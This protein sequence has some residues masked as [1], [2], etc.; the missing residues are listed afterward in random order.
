MYDSAGV[1][2]VSNTDVGIWRPG[3]E[4][5][6]EEELRIGAVEGDPGYLFGEIWGVTVDSQ[7]RIFVLDF[8]S[9]HI[10]VYSADGVYEQT[11]GGPGEGPGELRGAVSI[12]MGPGDTLLVRD[13]RAYRFNRYSPDGS[14][15]PGFRMAV[16]ERRLSGLKATPS[17]VMVEQFEARN[18][19]R[20]VFAPSE[21]LEEWI[22]RL[23]TDGTILDTLLAYSSSPLLGPEGRPHRGGR[24][25]IPE[26]M[27]DV[28]DDLELVCGTNDEYRIATYSN[29][30]LERIITKPFDRGPVSDLKRE[31]LRERFYAGAPPSASQEVLDRM[32]SG[33]EK[34]IADFFPVFKD[35]AV[36]TMG[37]LWVQHVQPVSELSEE[38]DFG[39]FEGGAVEWDVFDPEGRFL[40][41]VAM[42]HRFRPMVFR[43]DKIYGT[44]YDEYDVPYVVR[45]RIVGDLSVGPG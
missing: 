14:S 4:W 25:Y 41:V 42:P 20:R 21:V 12:F 33:A 23:A 36:G 24:R 19:D 44:W 7:G 45:L 11:L 31:T 9:Q 39:F 26:M 5:T 27:W 35:L 43:G 40:G 37:S 8:Q 38:E 10:Q 1:T 17:G 30:R 28:S 29:R 16:E 34:N 18:N 15:V 6:L 13:N 3:E 2:I 32:W 22:V